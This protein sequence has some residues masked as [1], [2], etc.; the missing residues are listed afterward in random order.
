VRFPRVP[1]P[2]DVLTVAERTGDLVEQL[3]GTLP[4][5]MA[6]LDAAERIVVDL[7]ALVVAAAAT[8][9]RLG[10]LLDRLEPSLTALQPTLA[11]LAETTDPREVDALVSLVDRMPVLAE[12][13]ERDVVPVMR[14]LGSVS[15]DLHDLLE[16]SRELNDMLAKLPG[17]GRIK[18]RV[19]AQQN[20][21]EA[22]S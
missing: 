6:L 18:R 14:T 7:D 22:R 4:R 19:D 12:Q 2:R 13:V 15:P 3:I 10:D 21:E 20:A 16:T 1:G 8:E 11:R 17:M 9:A 5:V